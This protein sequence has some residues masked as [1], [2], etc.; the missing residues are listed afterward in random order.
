MGQID[1]LSTF[2]EEHV[3]EER[4]RDAIMS[5]K[6]DEMSEQIKTLTTQ[7]ESLIT[8]WNQAKG[9]VSFIKWVVGIS[10]SVAAFILFIKDHIK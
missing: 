5:A 8:A 7:M 1:E 3:D 9:V 2:L 4:V 10:G 6:I